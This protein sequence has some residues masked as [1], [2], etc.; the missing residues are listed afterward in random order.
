MDGGTFKIL[1]ALIYTIAG[2]PIG[3]FWFVVGY[4]LYMTGLQGGEGKAIAAFGATAMLFFLSWF[5]AVIPAFVSGFAV[6]YFSPSITRTLAAAILAPTVL[7]TVAN[8]V[9][10]SIT[11]M[12]LYVFDSHV[13][14]VPLSGL[15]A[16]MTCWF[17]TL[18]LQRR[19]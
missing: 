3:M 2:P 17:L 7:Y 18:P 9:G 6:A 13:L 12:Q 15:A 5:F 16:S 19:A 14:A 8:L 11:G 1:I 4:F 10:L